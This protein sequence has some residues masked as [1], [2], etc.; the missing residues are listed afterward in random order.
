MCAPRGTEFYY[1]K[2]YFIFSNLFLS[3]IWL[4]PDNSYFSQSPYMA[5]LKAEQVMHVAAP[6]PHFLLASLA[7]WD[8]AQ[9]RASHQ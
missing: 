9:Q 8:P 1:P 5:L 2:L 4:K 3:H 6:A 7:V